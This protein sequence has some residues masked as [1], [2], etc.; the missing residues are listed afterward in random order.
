MMKLAIL[1]ALTGTTAAFAP[2]NL[3]G[4]LFPYSRETSDFMV[5]RRRVR[6]ERYGD[7][8]VLSVGVEVEVVI[9]WAHL[10]FMVFILVLGSFEYIETR[11]PRI[12]Q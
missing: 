5:L 8:E 3:G 1:A 11:L 6:I 10:V 7:A 12:W 4:M 2:A 9:A